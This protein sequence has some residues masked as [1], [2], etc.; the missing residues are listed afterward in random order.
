MGR[1]DQGVDKS[2]GRY[3][4]VPRTL[5]FV[6]YGTDVLLLKG[7]PTKPIWP[8]RYNGVGGHVERDEDI[9]SAAVREV[10]EETGLTVEDVR[11]RAVINVDTD[12]PQAGILLFVFTARARS[13][14]VRPSQEGV[15]EWV[16]QARILEYDLVEDLAELLP[17]ILA[18]GLDDQPLF[19][20]YHYDEEDRLMIK[21]TSMVGSL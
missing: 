18:L 13:Q 19:G 15:L 8:N 9:F 17:K 20:R 14:D 10:T 5:C 12:D 6:T 21:W 4:V 1:Q 7:A 2:Q 3:H 11:L 16:P